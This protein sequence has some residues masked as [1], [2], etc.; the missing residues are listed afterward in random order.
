MF[1]QKQVVT[2]LQIILISFILISCAGKKKLQEIKEDVKQEVKAVVN[3]V[4]PPPAPSWSYE[5]ETGPEHWGTMEAKFAACSEGQTQSPINLKW[6]KPEESGKLEFSYKD[7]SLK[8]IDNGHTLQ[9]H[10]EQGSKVS[11]NG[12]EYDLIQMHFHTPSEHTIANKSYPLE[13]H[14]VHQ[15]V[16][17]RLAVIGVMFTESKTNDP[18]IDALW[19]FVPS[20]KNKQMDI[21]DFKLNPMKLIPSKHT[22]YHYSGSLTTPPCTEGVNWNVLNTPVNI[23][24]SQI[25]AF[26]SLYHLNNRPVQSLNGRK[27]VNY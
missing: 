6:N 18:T 22:Y 26:R 16:L 24:K 7:S 12:E 14:F 21:P 13:V 10:Y 23:S 17:G 5:G 2:V 20:E 25:E 19:G 3:P 15:D 8:V 1:F 27:V 11:I 9:F 4:A